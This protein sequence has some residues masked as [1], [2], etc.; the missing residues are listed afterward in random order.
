MIVLHHNAGTGSGVVPNCWINRQASAHYQIEDG[1]I[2]SCLDEELVA[3]H[4]GAAGYDN[5]GHT[6]GIEHQNSTGDPSWLVSPENQEKS[7]QLV[8]EIATRRGIPIDR[9]HIVRHREMPNCATVCS[10]GLNIDWIVNRAKEIASGKPAQT[11]PEQAKKK[12]LK[13][14]SYIQLTSKFQGFGLTFPKDSVWEYNAEAHT[15]RYIGNPAAL[16]AL[17]K[18]NEQ[19]DL[20]PWTGADLLT[21]VQEFYL[22]VDKFSNIDS[23]KK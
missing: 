9:N 13:K 8:A 23:F 18:A 6:I 7:A 14:M 4:C 17:Q 3:W 2:I 10:G 16:A 15:F 12:G 11:M 20:I 1:K 21:V 19:D 22:G 5:N